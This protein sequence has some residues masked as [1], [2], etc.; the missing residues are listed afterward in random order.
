MDLF[1]EKQNI[2]NS[3]KVA[4]I[5]LKKAIRAKPDRVQANGLRLDGIEEGGI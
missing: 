5:S 3:V 4:V 1:S 2:V